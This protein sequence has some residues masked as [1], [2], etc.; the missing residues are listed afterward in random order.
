MLSFNSVKEIVGRALPW[1]IGLMSISLVLYF[2]WKLF[3]ALLSWKKT[4]IYAK[5][6]I[7]AS[8]IFTSMPGILCSNSNLYFCF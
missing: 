3:G 5:I 6:A 7:S 2:H 4:P 1:S 8:M